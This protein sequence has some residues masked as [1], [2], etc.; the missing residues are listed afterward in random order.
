MSASAP[1]C[2]TQHAPLDEGAHEHGHEHGAC[3]HGAE[4]GGSS[5]HI[6]RPRQRK[7]LLLCIVLTTVTCAVEVVGGLWTGSLMLLSD[8]IHMASHAVALVVSYIA[9]RLASRPI[10]ARSHYGFFRAEIL[11]AFLN[12]IGVLAFSAFIVWEAVERL[13]HPGTVMAGEATLLAAI[14]LL[15]NLNTAL[16]L[17]RAG[18]HDLNT[19]SAYVHML[20]DTLSS[21]AILVGGFVLWRTGWQWIDPV[22]SLGV[23]VVVLIWGFGLLRDSTAI[24]LELSPREA[25]SERVR[26][27]LL[28]GVP[29]LVDVH[30]LHVWEITS[31][32]LCATAHLVVPGQAVSATSELRGAVEQLLRERFQVGHVTLQL[33]SAASA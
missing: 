28:E 25:D 23:A 1:N 18:A 30:D 20:G 27:A 7:G 26:A 5:L 21:V 2:H 32:Y 31:G 13:M 9:L 4:H 33:E 11:G 12:G 19:R 24:L 3:S 14:G 17:A 6:H 22:L 15:V 29:E 8:A 10:G 16:L